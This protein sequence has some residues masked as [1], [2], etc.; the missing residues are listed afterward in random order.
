M[1]KLLFAV[2]ALAALALLAPSTGFAQGA[3][4]QLGFYTDG[5]MSGTSVSGVAPYGQVSCFLVISNPWN[6][7][8][9]QS[10]DSIGGF[11]YSIT[12]DDGLL[13]LSTDFVGDALDIDSSNT[14]DIVGIG[15]PYPVGAGGYIHIATKV[16]MYQVTDGEPKFIKLGPAVPATNP[17]YM[18]I[19]DGNG[20]GDEINMH[21]SSGDWDDP[22]FGFNGTV[23]ANEETSFGNLKALYR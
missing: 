23:V 22:V 6:T 13:I 16:V 18:V 7:D 5:D 8:T 9:D 21:P 10:I 12:L 17:G 14:N 20:S 15:N 3:Y 4:N 1:K 19:L 2:S 11:E